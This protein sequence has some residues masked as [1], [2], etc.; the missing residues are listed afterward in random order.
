ME[1]LKKWKEAR[2]F[3]KRLK[4]CKIPENEVL[5]Y[6]HSRNEKRL[7]K[8]VEA[9]LFREQWLSELVDYECCQTLYEYVV[10]YGRVSLEG[11]RYLASLSM[12]KLAQLGLQ[13]W[14]IDEM[15]YA[16]LNLD[17]YRKLLS[18]PDNGLI[19]TFLWVRKYAQIST[20]VTTDDVS[21]YTSPMNWFW[22]VTIEVSVVLQTLNEAVSHLC[23]SP[24]DQMGLLRLNEESIIRCFLNI[25]IEREKIIR[26]L[27]REQALDEEPQP[28]L[29]DEVRAEVIRLGYG[30]MLFKI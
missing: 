3:S 30:E 13:Q 22:G 12:D 19:H 28:Y 16:G 24:Q 5:E 4:Q 7:C 26:L 8:I 10:L 21:L 29:S 27:R 20:C 9:F 25:G 18:C 14:L 11:K 6:I 23:F 1:L 2:A 17:G 15:N